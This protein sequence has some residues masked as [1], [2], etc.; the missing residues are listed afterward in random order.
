MEDKCYVTK[1]EIFMSFSKSVG[2][3]SIVNPNS[4][5]QV[6]CGKK[7]AFSLKLKGQSNNPFC[8]A[9]KFTRFN[10]HRG[11]KCVKHLSVLVS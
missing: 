4:I 3:K 9:S 6:D 10:F 5:K 8:A 11:V 1:K 7:S 2:A